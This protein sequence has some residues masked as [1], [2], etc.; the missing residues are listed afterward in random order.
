MLFIYGLLLYGN[1][2]LF[3]TTSHAAFIPFT[4]QNAKKTVQK[5]AT[6]FA[7]PETT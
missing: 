7:S 1:I 2:I 6:Q 5:L 4:W 3:E